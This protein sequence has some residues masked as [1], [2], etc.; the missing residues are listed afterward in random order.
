MDLGFLKESKLGVKRYKMSSTEIIEE[1]QEKCY[2]EVCGDECSDDRWAC[3]CDTCEQVR[4]PDCWD[5]VWKCDKGHKNKK[6]GV[7]DCGCGYDHDKYWEDH[8]DPYEEEEE[9]WC[10]EHEQVMYNKYGEKC[11][12]C[13][14]EEQGIN[15]G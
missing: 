11:A 10:E 6:I 7:C 9:E 4:C 8:N 3:E 15:R 2:C 12:A 13:L 5:A 14:D 1:E